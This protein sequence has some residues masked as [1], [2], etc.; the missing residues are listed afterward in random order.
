MTIDDINRMLIRH[1]GNRLKPYADCCGKYWRDCE[2]Q[3]K[4]KLTIGVGRN[5]DDVGISAQESNYLLSND[6]SKVMAQCRN[7]LPWFNHLCDARKMVIIDMVFNLGMRRFLEFQATIAAI[8]AGDFALAASRMLDSK[9][10]GQ[11][12]YRAREDAHTMETGEYS[13]LLV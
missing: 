7:E 1:E 12:G 5:L 11:V 13:N 8:I 10:A 6:V 4:G 9:W 3:N 2:C